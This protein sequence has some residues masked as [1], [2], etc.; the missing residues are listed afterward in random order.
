M[1]DDKSKECETLTIRQMLDEKISPG[2]W[3]PCT[4]PD[5]DTKEGFLNAMSEFWDRTV[6]KHG[7][8]GPLHFVANERPAAK[9]RA[10]V[11]CLVLAGSEESMWNLRFFA[12]AKTHMS[13]L[14]R[15]DRANSYRRKEVWKKMAESDEWRMEVDEKMRANDCEENDG[16]KEAINE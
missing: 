9:N 11:V 14:E 3:Y 2:E 13:I 8:A 12:D 4:H 10:K 7:K 6:E 1:P 5:T 15:G 16:A